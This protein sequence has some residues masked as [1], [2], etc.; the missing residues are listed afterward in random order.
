MSGARRIL[1]FLITNTLGFLGVGIC[2]Y[3]GILTHTLDLSDPSFDAA[4]FKS[5]FIMGT[6]TAW[7]ICAVLSF[8]W[9]FMK[10]R[11]RFVFLWAPA[12]V[13]IIYGLSVLNVS[14]P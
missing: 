10:G 2:F 8:G 5:R 4:S 13:P 3:I 11:L 12:L 6:M 1:L 14:P 9:F 7:L